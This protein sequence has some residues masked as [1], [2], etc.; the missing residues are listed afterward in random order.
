MDG[1]S[2]TAL[3][4]DANTW[5][6]LADA[7]MYFEAED[8]RSVA[9]VQVCWDSC[10]CFCAAKPDLVNMWLIVHQQAAFMPPAQR[11]DCACRP[12]HHKAMAA[13]RQQPRSPS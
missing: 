11:M 4:V 12:S 5:D 10:Y 3:L 7:K 8:E 9:G 6:F 13:T 1:T 2:S